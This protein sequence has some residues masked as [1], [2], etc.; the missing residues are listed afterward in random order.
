MRG[1]AFLKKELS[2]ALR[3]Y[4]LLILGIVFFVF[5]MMGP[6]TAKLMPELMDAFLPEGMIL[7]LAAPSAMD[8]WAQFFKN[9]PQMGLVIVVILF[10]GMLA[11]EYSRGTLV[12]MLTKGLPRRA[13]ILAKF[14]ASALLWTAA[15][16][17]C[18]GISWAYTVFL[19]PDGRA[20]SLLFAVG[21]VW[22]FGLTLLAILILGGTLLRNSY[23]CLLLTGAF[24]VL[25][26]V[27]NM[28]PSLQVY[29][30]ILLVTGNM[31][32]LDGSMT[33]WDFLWP[34]IISAALI[35]LSLTASILIFNRKQ[36]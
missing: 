20:N 34:C 7:D 30:P 10:S 22:L 19:F 5:G 15:Y 32:L 13:V 29:N 25:L 17:L 11:S 14:G 33:L 26:F 27:L 16:L 1:L 9:I 6:L 12:N 24:V 8:S 3:S 35:P 21:C 23:S 2:E 4:R 28:F 18:F 36:F 31:A